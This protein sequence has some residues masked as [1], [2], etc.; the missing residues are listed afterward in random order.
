MDL[1]REPGGGPAAGGVDR[2][3]SIN[4][5]RH[6]VQLLLKTIITEEIAHGT[7]NGISVRR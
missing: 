3:H 1:R 2:L 6:R 4:E 5:P 7:F